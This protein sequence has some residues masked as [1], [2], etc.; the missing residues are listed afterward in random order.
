MTQAFKVVNSAAELPLMSIS[1]H[2][3]SRA[4]MLLGLIVTSIL[5][6]LTAMRV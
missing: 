3:L 2:A 6:E 1:S 4:A 5:K